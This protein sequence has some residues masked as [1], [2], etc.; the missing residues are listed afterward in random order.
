MPEQLSQSHLSRQSKKGADPLAANILIV[1]DE[2]IVAMDIQ[3]CL[4]NLGYSV[5]IV[6]DTGEEAISHV[7]KGPPD[8]VLMD[9]RLAGEMDGVEAAEIVRSRFD[10]P[11]VYLT[12]QVDNHTLERAKTTGPFGYVLKPF[13][14]RD[15]HTTIEMALAKHQ[16]E[17]RLRESEERLRLV[18]ENALDAVVAMDERGTI[19]EWN[20]QAEKIFGWSREE[21]LDRN[22]AETI[23]PPQHREDHN[24]GLQQFLA[25][26]TGLLLNRRL[27]EFTA[28]HRDGH[29]FP[30][31]L[32]ISPV[33]Y[34]NTYSFSAFVRDITDRR[35]ARERLEKSEQKY[36]TLVETTDTGY[37]IVDSE[38]TV[39]DANSEYVRLTGHLTL[40]EI[41]GRRVFE[42]ISEGDL[43]RAAE[44]FDR[45]LESGF[46]R[47]FEIDY[48][49]TN[50]SVTPI[51]INAR[52][53]ET[54]KG[55]IILGLC[56]DITERHEVEL[57]L[58]QS[59]S[60]LEEYAYVVSHDLKDPLGVIMRHVQFLE[61]RYKD[62]LDEGA[63]DHISKTIQG[64]K[65]MERLINEL[66]ANA[67][68][69][70]GSV[71]NVDC[72][73][74]LTAVLENLQPVI[75]DVGATVTAERLPTVKANQTEVVQVFQNLIGNAIKFRADDRP[76][77]I[78]IG[79]KTNGGVWCFS[80]QDNGIGMAGEHR[81][82]VF[83]IF[84]RIGEKNTEGTG[85]GLAN[86]KKAVERRGGEIWVDSELG[87]GSTF[88]FTL[89]DPGE[90][91]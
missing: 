45:C 59:N 39:L 15:L 4:T 5:P 79:C 63:L 17:K 67:E 29:E 11:V 70:R 60:D 50:G 33:K 25:T 13:E 34:G 55:R 62:A 85:I 74:V 6:V 72:E 41:L 89:P 42:W 84:E 49:D 66:K 26:G 24:R 61:R 71:E 12:A 9:I 36:R 76:L 64:T 54:D 23:I 30:I 18:I 2:H 7:A 88:F 58:R 82:R 27:D 91:R 14:E 51:E 43:Q 78:H 73:S 77:A 40:Q 35:Q 44:E 22:L 32:S 28:I 75:S 38:G 31:E 83:Q 3:V 48:V 57:A 53:L 56:R 1:E 68:I 10:V 65:Y 52:V 80:V 21:V 8:L 86:C 90:D 87:K 46:V 19:T 16:M 69:G 81:S 20:P 47:G 37:V